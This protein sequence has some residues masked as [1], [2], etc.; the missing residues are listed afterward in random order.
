MASCLQVM[1]VLQ[2]YLDG[3]TDEMTARR[4]ANHLEACR[5]CGMEASIYRE[6]KAALARQAK[7]L[8]DESLGRLRQFSLSLTQRHDAEDSKPGADEAPP[9]A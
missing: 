6:M 9:S 3:H 5:R 8:D 4:V 2:S 1:R 7:P